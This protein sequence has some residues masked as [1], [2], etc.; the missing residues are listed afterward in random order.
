MV[1]SYSTWIKRKKIVTI[2]CPDEE[3]WE[4]LDKNTL[5]LKECPPS[6]DHSYDLKMRLRRQPVLDSSFIENISHGYDRLGYNLFVKDSSVIC[7]VGRWLLWKY[8]VCED[9]KIHVDIYCVHQK[10]NCLKSI[11]RRMLG[12]VPAHETNRER[13]LYFTRIGIHF[14]L[15]FML[16][17]K[18]NIGVM[19]AAAVA[20]GGKS[21]VLAG[22]D[23]VGKSTLA[24]Y[25]C[26]KCGFQYVADNF[27][28]YDDT[29]VYP[30]A[31]GARM[32]DDSLR[33]L[34]FKCAGKRIHGRMEVIPPSFVE[35]IPLSLSAVYFNSISH[36][37]VIE[38]M[39]KE[40]M[41]KNIMSM[42]NYLPEFIDYKYFLS[43]VNLANNF[44]YKGYTNP[45]DSF[46]SRGRLFS[47]KKARITDMAFTAR[48]IDE[49]I[50]QD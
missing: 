13:M 42:E 9:K 26:L 1:K 5:W 36:T 17:T 25:L 48:K 8:E 19:H 3:Y 31:E 40:Q 24:L 2:D 41:K 34:D 32:N 10:D 14:P 23:G 29:Y 27:L 28:L 30:F 45:L 47:L 21:V 43:A 18:E 44:D 16:K 50:V 12:R 49:C 4:F 33:A 38:E 20:K 15:F 46:L 37:D 35:D 11:A 22:Y 7:L 6:S 39:S